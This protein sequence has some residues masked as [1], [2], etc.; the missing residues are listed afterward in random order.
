MKKFKRFGAVFCA[1]IM[2]L[3]L[4]SC[5]TT[6]GDT[7]GGT[8]ADVLATA[9]KKLAEVD[10]M[11]ATMTMDMDFS[12]TSEGQGYDIQ[13]NTVM[14]MVMFNDPLKVKVGATIN[15]TM[16]G[17]G[18]QT[19]DMAM[20]MLGDDDNY[21]MYMNQDGKWYSEAVDMR[22]IEQ[23][24]PQA[25]MELYLKNADSFTKVAEETINDVKT[26][27]YSGVITGAAMEEVINSSGMLDNISGMGMDAEGMDLAA[28][29]QNMGDL[30]I[31]IWIDEEGYPVR[32]EMDM[33]DVM[34]KMFEQIL[35]QPDMADSGATMN[36][37][38]VFVSMDCFNFNQADD[39]E[40][41]A[42][43]LEAQAS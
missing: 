15:M 36:C 1:A 2:A 37:T 5:G 21:T 8:P 30:P 12:M 9:E 39:F 43:A 33:K 23:Y 13:S 24:D 22:Y 40:V 11:E 28:L 38:K 25:S 19:M 34:N 29:Y 26:T 3:A 31:S 18:E 14:N 6:N 7:T 10:S 27:K 42:E 32:Y 16:S 4:T 41:P 35:A 20:Y 17:L